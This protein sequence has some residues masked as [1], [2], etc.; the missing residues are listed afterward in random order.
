[1]TNSQR[2]TLVKI[3]WKCDYILKRKK[4]A[5]N[6]VCR[7]CTLTVILVKQNTY[8]SFCLFE[9]MSK[10]C[11]DYHAFLQEPK[12]KLT[13]HK[14]THFPKDLAISNFEL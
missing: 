4:V 7:F 6:S 10:E 8:E 9:N 14:T 1:M 5:N 13:K 2:C 12:S 3:W 11:Q